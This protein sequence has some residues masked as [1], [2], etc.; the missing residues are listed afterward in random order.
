MLICIL[1][2][3]THT[4]P[5]TEK[6]S[7]A[8]ANNL[9]G[10]KV[11][12]PS[13]AAVHVSL[14]GNYSSIDPP[15]S[16]VN[17]VHTG[18]LKSFETA[19]HSPIA[20]VAPEG[21]TEKTTSQFKR[22]RKEDAKTAQQKSVNSVLPLQAVNAVQLERKRKA[23][24]TQLKTDTSAVAVA[25]QGVAQLAVADDV[26]PQTK[27]VID[28]PGA[29]D[30]GD[31]GVIERHSR[32][33]AEC[34]AVEFDNEKDVL[35]RVYNTEMSPLAENE[36]EAVALPAEY[37][38]TAVHGDSQ[39]VISG[40]FDLSDP[41][42]QT[43][44]FVARN[45]GVYIGKLNI[46]YYGDGKFYLLDIKTDEDSIPK[47]SRVKGLGTVLLHIAGVMGVRLNHQL[48]E[49]GATKFPKTPHPA[50]FYA[51]F[52]FKSVESLA[53][54][55]NSL[56]TYLQTIKDQPVKMNVA[57]DDLAQTTGQY[58]S[59]NNWSFGSWNYS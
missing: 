55:G 56:T 49:L 5:A 32:S 46:S 7:K 20:Q 50:T 37:N 18:Q 47:V 31:T 13:A 40:T 35:Y 58:L 34:Q 43:L 33:V 41:N 23:E 21:K 28:N 51:K 14:P 8:S 22:E 57:S 36:T 3:N 9:S 11:R 10:G 54:Y 1:S 59:A 44:E 4:L 6:E 42:A 26:P 24:T 19:T 25:E 15:L 27:I 45:A 48:I 39:V 17:A 53:N 12:Q 38:I 30:F 29:A 16:S 52:G 2:M